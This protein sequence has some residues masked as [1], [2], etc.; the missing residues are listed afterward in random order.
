MNLN[1]LENV[2]KKHDLVVV[3]GSYGRDRMVVVD[4]ASKGCGKLNR[5]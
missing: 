4:M 1:E 2:I 5:A 3:D